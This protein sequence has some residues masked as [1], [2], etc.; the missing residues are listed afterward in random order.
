[1]EVDIRKIA[2][3]LIGELNNESAAMK[4][5]AEGVALLY[6]RLRQTIEQHSQPSV[7]AQGSEQPAEK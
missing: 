3:D 7:E 6:E 4:L 1:M 5:R 2:Q